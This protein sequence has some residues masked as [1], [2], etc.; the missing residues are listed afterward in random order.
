[1]LG[2]S[3]GCYIFFE[4]RIITSKKAIILKFLIKQSVLESNYRSQNILV[5][6]RNP[7]R[8]YAQSHLCKRFLGGTLL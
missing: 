1:M 2:C 8:I 5:F 3:D 7:S 6:K 4:K